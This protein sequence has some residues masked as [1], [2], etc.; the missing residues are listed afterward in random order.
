[1]LH[2]HDLE[3][4]DEIARYRLCHEKRRIIKSNHHYRGPAQRITDLEKAFGDL[5]LGELA[6]ALCRLLKESSPRIYKDL[7]KAHGLTDPDRLAD[8]LQH[9]R[10]NGRPECVRPTWPPQRTGGALA[11]A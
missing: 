5:I 7:L 2:L 6:T 3:T 8:L 11:S 10:L 9:S 1:M 4:G